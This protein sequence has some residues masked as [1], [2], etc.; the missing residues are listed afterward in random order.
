MQAVLK[1]QKCDNISIRIL[2]LV[3]LSINNYT[4]D[5]L[6]CDNTSICILRLVA[7]S[8]NNYTKDILK[9][10]NTSICMLR[11]V[12][13]SIDNYTKEVPLLLQFCPP[14]GAAMLV[15]CL[16]TKSRKRRAHDVFNTFATHA[17][18]VY[19]VTN[20]GCKCCTKWL[21]SQSWFCNLQ[22]L[23]LNKLDEKSSVKLLWVYYFIPIDRAYNAS[24]VWFPFKGSN[25]HS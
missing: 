14:Q 10:D 1:I 13:L 22:T 17:G 5:T 19:K 20:T 16:P 21:H 3:V 8:I 25:W 15:Y 12:A 7:L 4:K 2:C 18:L 9:C 11:L 6:K 24:S 23:I